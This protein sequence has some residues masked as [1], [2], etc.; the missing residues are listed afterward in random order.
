MRLASALLLGTLLASTPARADD[1]ALL[2]VS[3][4]AQPKS[5]AYVGPG[6]IVSGA[7]AF[8]GLQ[9]YNA[10]YAAP[11]TNS[12]INIRRAS[13]NASTNIV[14]LKTGLLDVATASTFCASTTCYI[15]D[16]YDQTGNGNTLLQFT[17]AAQPQLVFN[18]I[19]SLPCASLNGTQDMYVLSLSS[20]GSSIWMML[21][22]ERTGNFTGQ[23][24]GLFSGNGPFIGWPGTANQAL[25][26]SGSSALTAAATDSALHAIQGVINGSAGTLDVD[27]VSTSAS[28]GTAT[29]GGLVYV[30]SG[31]GGAFYLTGE[32]TEAGVWLLAPTSAQQSAM[33]SNMASRWGSP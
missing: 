8:W 21:E 33:H 22:G 30:G 9:A 2:G 24:D 7:T 6:D 18:C 25:L 28:V 11:G 10:A 19:G 20:S 13:D 14:I 17:A 16:W 31:S 4:A 27:G 26:F 1:M 15:D 32:I 29:F 12:A 23:S 3:N 5:A